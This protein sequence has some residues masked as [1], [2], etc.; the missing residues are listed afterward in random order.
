MRPFAALAA[1][2]LVVAMGCAGRLGPPGSDA[3]NAPAVPEDTPVAPSSPALHESPV[4]ASIPRCDQVA[5]IFAQR[6]YYRD[7]PIYVANE[8]PV[9]EVR[10]W[11]VRQP[12]FEEIWIDRDHL[13]WIA[14][15]F[16]VEAEARQAELEERFPG[17]GVV[18]V[19]VDWTMAE[20]HAL[21]RRVMDELSAIAT[22]SSISVT[23]GVVTIGL[24]VLK[25]KRIAAVEEHFAAE[26]VCIEG[27]DPAD[28]PAEGPQQPSGDGWRLLADEQGAGAPYRTIA[29]GLVRG[30]L[31]GDRIARR[32]SGRGLPV[33]GGDLFRRGVRLELPGNTA[34]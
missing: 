18:A 17:V 24:G 33:P 29:T 12:G 31:E 7:S 34:R 21:Q 16:S 19:P 4:T 23:Q 32:Y 25:R 1:L 2:A 13:G 27:V 30:S 3:P 10:D 9:E 11:A 6:E 28:A 14:V 5:Q 26:R 8:M 15:A 22:S 20:L